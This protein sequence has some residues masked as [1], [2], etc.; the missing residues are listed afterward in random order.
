M[1]EVFVAT[2]PIYDYGKT[3]ATASRT[4]DSHEKLL[5]DVMREVSVGLEKM[6]A[7]K[8]TRAIAKIHSIAENVRNRQAQST[9]R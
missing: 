4:G 7:T 8:R 6:P 1:R 2:H 5:N 3:D 9:G